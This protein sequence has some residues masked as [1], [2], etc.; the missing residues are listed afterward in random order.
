[1]GINVVGT[2]LLRKTQRHVEDDK[3][4]RAWV[5]SHHLSGRVVYFVTSDHRHGYWDR[6]TGDVGWTPND[7]VICLSSCDRFKNRK[8]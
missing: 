7:E 4:D 6:L 1:M 5:F 8:T 2:K 3:I